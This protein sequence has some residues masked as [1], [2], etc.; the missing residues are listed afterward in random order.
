MFLSNSILLSLVILF[1]H[2]PNKLLSKLLK[3]IIKAISLG[4]NN[5]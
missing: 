3:L 2:V 5:G 4:K 1:K